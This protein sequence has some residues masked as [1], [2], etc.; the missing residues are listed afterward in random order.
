MNQTTLDKMRRMRLFGMYHAFK[1]GMETPRS[2]PY[3]ADKMT[4]ML[5]ESEWDDRHNRTLDRG[6]RNA[7][8][9]YVAGTVIGAICWTELHRFSWLQT[10]SVIFS[11]GQSSQS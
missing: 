3:T 9:L 5:I 11:E 1:S 7:R 8:F 2:E 10:I 4:S 6:L